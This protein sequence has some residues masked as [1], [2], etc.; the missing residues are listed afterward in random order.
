MPGSLNH[1]VSRVRTLYRKILQLHRA[2]P[3]ELKTLGDQ[4]VK[5]EFRRHRSVGPEEAQCFLREW[6]NYAATL[7]QQ[8]N[9]KTQDSTSHPR[10]GSHLPEDKLHTLRDEQVGQLQELMQE[11]TKPKRQFNILDDTDHKN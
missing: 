1:H 10:F 7:S 9:P 3:L 8:T 6:E 11:A 4:Y 5:D 2:L